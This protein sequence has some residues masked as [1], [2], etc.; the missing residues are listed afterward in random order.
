[1]FGRKPRR[2]EDE[3]GPAGPGAAGQ[4]PSSL[5]A[6]C[7]GCGDVVVDVD[8]TTV[9]RAHEGKGQGWYS[10]RCPRCRRTVDVAAPQHLITVLVCLGAAE[11]ELSLPEEL[12][13]RDDPPL[14][15]DDV[16]DLSLRLRETEDLVSLLVP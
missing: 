16:L 2:P 9:V 7:P 12:E 5:L 3:I 14:T 15:M 10:F 8:R 4:A 11:S 1:M 13:Q 6:T